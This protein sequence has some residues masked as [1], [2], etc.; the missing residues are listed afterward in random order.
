LFI[1][2]PAEGYIAGVTGHA[3]ALQRAQEVIAKRLKDFDYE[4]QLPAG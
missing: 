1:G 4:H 3:Q 2:L